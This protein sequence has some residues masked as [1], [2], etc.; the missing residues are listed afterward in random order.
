MPT[1][2]PLAFSKCVTRGERKIRA[3]WSSGR[4]VNVHQ[5]QS[6]YLLAREKN[7]KVAHRQSS[8]V[9]SD[10]L[11]STCAPNRGLPRAQAAQ[12]HEKRHM[13]GKERRPSAGQSGQSGHGQASNTN[14]PSHQQVKA[15][16]EETERRLYF[17]EYGAL[18]LLC[19]FFSIYM[20]KSFRITHLC[21]N[22]EHRLECASDE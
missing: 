15:K 11:C 19:S 10:D 9:A 12:R 3:A 17:P 7:R 18:L 21:N 5:F 2:T 6:S 13:Q 20:S 16:Y 22:T 14:L 4:L 8:K 1:V